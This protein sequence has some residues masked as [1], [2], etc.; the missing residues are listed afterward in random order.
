MANNFGDDPVH[1][2]PDPNYKVEEYVKSAH[3]IETQTLMDEL[4]VAP[5]GEKTEAARNALL[6]HI[7]REEYFMTQANGTRK[8]ILFNGPPRSGKDTAVD[9]AMNYLE[10]RGERYRFAS[11]LKDG[12]HA[13]FGFKGVDTEFFNK[14]KDNALEVFKAVPDCAH[15]DINTPRQAYIYMSEECLK[16]V[17]GKDFFARVA[18]R[19]IT[20]MRH[21]VVV[22]SDCGFDEEAG[23]LVEA[24]G[25]ENIAIVHMYRE[26]CS[27]DNDSRKYVTNTECETFNIYNDGSVTD[28]YDK[29]VDVIE[30]FA[31]PNDAI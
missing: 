15:S 5:K 1:N 3:E 29:V 6:K 24:F 14:H 18:V 10:K 19:N 20:N 11:P 7:E 31:G 26:G 17:F 13:L 8:I 16:P 25:K 23:A 28:L 12:V 9:F 4:A 2:E 22:I 21:P 30:K 27:F